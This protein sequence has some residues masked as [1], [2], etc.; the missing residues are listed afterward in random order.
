MFV[1]FCAKYSPLITFN[2]KFLNKKDLTKEIINK[3]MIN[4]N[5]CY[6]LGKTKIFLNDLLNDKLNIELK[7]SQSAAAATIQSVWRMYV[8]RNDYKLKLKSVRSLQKFKLSS[9]SSETSVEQLSN[10]AS[11]ISLTS[12]S[13][14]LNQD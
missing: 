5:D 14:S 3:Q 8:I 1:V 6:R 10:S 11:T 4:T 7:R 9:T 13:S 12:C 2:K